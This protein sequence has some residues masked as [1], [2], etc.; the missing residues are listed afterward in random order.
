M[1]LFSFDCVAHGVGSVHITFPNIQNAHEFDMVK[2][3][4]DKKR[5][6]GG[7]ICFVG[8]L[9]CM[10]YKLAI[11]HLY[12]TR[13]VFKWML[14]AKNFEFLIDLLSLAWT[15]I[16]FALFFFSLRRKS[17]T[18]DSGFTRWHSHQIIFAES[19]I[20][21]SRSFVR[22]PDKIFR[23]MFWLSGNANAMSKTRLISCIVQTNWTGRFALTPEWNHK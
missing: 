1:K 5:F 17:I 4:E 18:D 8:F 11:I 23:M 7:A 2:F 21:M 9:L 10:S 12:R 20:R 19:E 6:R 16:G 3:D 22:A 15:W 14:K 13:F